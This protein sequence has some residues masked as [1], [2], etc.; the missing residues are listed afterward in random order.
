MRQVVLVAAALVLIGCGPDPNAQLP[1]LATP[2]KSGGASGTGGT[3]S[4]AGG[5]L[6]GSGGTTTSQGGSGGVNP[7]QGG[8]TG[9][10]GGIVSSGGTLGAGGD[11]ST[12][13]I[14]SSGGVVGSGGVLSSGGIGAAGS[15]GKVG[16]GGVSSMGGTTTPGSGALTT[17]TFGS[18]DE[19]CTPTRDISGGSTGNLGI[20]AICFR[21]ADDLTDWNCSNA[22]DRTIKINTVTAKCGSAPPPK[23]GSFYYF[24]I[25]SGKSESASIYWYYTKQGYG[26]HPVPT[27]GQYPAWVSGGSAAPCATTSTT[28]A[29]A[30]TP[31]IDSGS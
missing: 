2:S 3:S 4:G 6:H 23:A 29:G 31:S 8:T 7:F 20:G 11:N 26:P 15:G 27:C 12:G 28:D 10:S 24:D 30:S 18:G 16:T 19:P 17:Y 9:S 14:V 22:D 1:G 5:S 25:S 13:G 21:T